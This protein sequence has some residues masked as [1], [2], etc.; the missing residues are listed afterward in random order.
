MREGRARPR[1]HLFFVFFLFFFVTSTF[2][3]RSVEKEKGGPHYDR[4]CRCG[5]DCGHVKKAYCRCL[6][7]GGAAAMAR[8]WRDR[9]E[10]HT[11]ELQSR[12]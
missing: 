11:S 8:M 4:L 10:E 1:M 5:Q 6:S 2:S 3:G 7:N 12:P 9:S